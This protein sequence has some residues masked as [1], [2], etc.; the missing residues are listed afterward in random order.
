VKGYPLLE[1]AYRQV[2]S[3]GT[4]QKLIRLKE[5]EDVV[6]FLSGRTHN[7]EKRLQKPPEIS[8]ESRS[9]A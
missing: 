4:D 5:S 6:D 2:E 1:S 3:A 8:F 7:G 9:E